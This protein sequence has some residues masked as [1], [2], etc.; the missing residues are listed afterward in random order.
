MDSQDSEEFSEL[1]RLVTL[2]DLEKIEENIYRGLNAKSSSKQVFGGQVAAQALIAAGRTVAE[3]RNAHSL[4]AYFIRPGDP[5]VP[6]VYEV[7]PIRD[8][9]SFAT[10]RVVAIQH[11]EAIFSLMVSFQKL[12]ESVDHADPMP[13]VPQPESLPTLA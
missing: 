7:D 3:G 9:R 12:E 11:G 8:G 5:Q 2:L 4:H 6:I 10:R 1:D 13:D